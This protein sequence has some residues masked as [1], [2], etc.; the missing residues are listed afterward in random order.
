MLADLPGPKIRTGHFPDGGVQLTPG[1]LRHAASRRRPERR[2]VHHRSRTPRCSTTSSVGQPGAT[3]RRRDLDDR[4]SSIDADGAERADRDR[5]SRQR[6]A[7]ACTCRRRRCGS[8]RRPPEDLVLAETM[9]AAGVEYIAVS[10][11]RKASD[12]DEVRA[13]VGAPRPAGR[14]DRDAHGDRQPR[15]TSSPRPTRSWSPAATSASTARSRTCPTCRS[16]SCGTA[17][18]PGTPVITATQMLESMITAPSPTR[19]EVSD[20]AN[21]VFDGTDAVML[22]GETA[23]GRDPVGVV[24][25]M[26]PRRR[27]GGVARR[28]TGSGRP[29][30]AACSAATTTCELASIDRITGAVTHAAWQ[31]SLDAGG[32]GDPVLHP[33]RAHRAGDG[34]VPP[35]GADDRPVAGPVD[36]PLD[37]AD[38][39]RRSPCRS[40]RTHRPTRWSGSRSRP[41]SGHDLIAHGD[42]CSSWPGHRQADA[43]SAATGRAGH[44]GSVRP[45]AAAATDV[46]ADRAR[47]MTGRTR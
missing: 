13:I 8:P 2:G 30:S 27:A 18:S 10:F 6:S 34:Q 37:G 28:A 25:T 43:T 5:R 38:L 24:R 36:G 19:A 7:R 31:A 11:V 17:S 39:G 35:A 46:H 41:R 16:G 9:A 1:S 42:T 21:A 14:Q 23:I 32:R 45:V 40:T 47:R 26:A 20:I 29:A 33:Q 4:A 12:V 3:R 44:D 22:S 15:T